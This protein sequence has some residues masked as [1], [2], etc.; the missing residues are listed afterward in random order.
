MELEKLKITE[1]QKEELAKIEGGTIIG[2]IIGFLIGES[3]KSEY[4]NPWGAALL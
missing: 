2:K 3:S 4:R 1:L